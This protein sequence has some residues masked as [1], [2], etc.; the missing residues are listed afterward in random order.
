MTQP[1]RSTQAL[2]DELVRSTGCPDAPEAIRAKAREVIDRYVAEFGEPQLPISVDV[3]ASLCGIS[4][5]DDLP[6]HSP[7]AELV[8]DGSGGVTM[9]VHPDRPETRQRFS[10][11]HEISHTFFPDYATK[12]WCRP[13]ARYRDRLR[14][15]DYLETLCDIGA[16]ELLF[17]QPWFS[18]DAAGVT[19]GAGLIRLASTYH[20]SRE[21]T[22]RRYVETSSEPVAVVYFTWKLKPVQKG[23][24]GNPDQKNLFGISA[25]DA[26]R[27]ALKL[28]IEYSVASTSFKAEGHFLPR[29]KSV[30]NDGPLYRAAA[31]GQPADGE[32][33]LDLGQAAG[34]YRVWAVPLWTADEDL[35]VAGEQMVAAVLRPLNVRRPTKKRGSAGGPMLFDG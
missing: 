25:E 19:D 15:E 13:D 4:R 18:R 3:L 12:T 6:V 26:R 7:D 33:H 22:L 32:C 20:G 35:G 34:T 24:V 8:P 28:R 9:R 21:A 27:E 2:I 17:P 31:S 1:G 30:E 11:A 5:S 16:S 14:P 29:D 23:I 10:V